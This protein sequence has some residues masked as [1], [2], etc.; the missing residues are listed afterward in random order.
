MQAAYYTLFCVI[1]R[2]QQVAPRTHFSEDFFLIIRVC[3]ESFQ[4]A[5][6]YSA[7][8]IQLKAISF[9]RL[10]VVIAVSTLDGG[11]RNKSV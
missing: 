2:G 9:V 8:Y 4:R 1:Q 7:G 11:V 5:E 3:Y 10:G 6:R